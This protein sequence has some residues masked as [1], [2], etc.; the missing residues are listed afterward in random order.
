MR[1]AELWIVVL[2]AGVD[3]YPQTDGLGL[4]SDRALLARSH[5]TWRRDDRKGR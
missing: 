1:D 4:H 3:G 2:A 5:V